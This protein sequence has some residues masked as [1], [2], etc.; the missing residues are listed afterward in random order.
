MFNKKKTDKK[1]NDEDAQYQEAAE[2][3][4][5]E[6]GQTGSEYSAPSKAPPP[7]ATGS[8][9]I[10]IEKHSIYSKAEKDGNVAV[11]V[12][13]GVKNVSSEVIGSVQF[14]AVFYDGDGCTLDTV[15]HKTFELIP[16]TVRTLRIFS[17]TPQTDTVKSYY[18]TVLGM[19]K[20]PEPVVNDHEKLKILKHKLADAWAEDDIMQPAGIEIAIKNN[21]ENTIATAVFEVEFLDIEGNALEVVKHK[22]IEI[23]KG[24]SR[25]VLVRSSKNEPGK[26]KS[27]NIN[28][29]RVSTADI[30]KIQFRKQEMRKNQ[31]G[32]EEVSGT[33]K[34]VSDS[35]ADTAIV[36]TFYNQDKES[37]GTRVLMLKD[38]EPGIVK[39]FKLL[40]KPQA[41]DKV[42]T[43]TLHIGDVLEEQTTV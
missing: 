14:E 18:V 28:I 19:V 4:S 39:P 12:E 11:G 7:M 25:A 22:E 15:K 32:E 43:C 27:Y 40:F 33:V 24:C 8:D 13:L 16:D 29:V 34:N 5:S 36:A 23:K 2:Q 31:S 17:E 26:I 35:K 20:T 38:I 9:V 37:I 30:E 1:T 10:T 42:R 6:I 41:G 21:S 3:E